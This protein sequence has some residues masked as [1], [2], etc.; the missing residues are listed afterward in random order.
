MAVFGAAAFI[1]DIVWFLFIAIIIQSL[2][3][4]ALAYFIAILLKNT[5]IPLIVNFT[6]S[7]IF[8]LAGGN[9]SLNIFAERLTDASSLGK[10]VWV[11]IAAFILLYGG[12]QMEKHLYKNSI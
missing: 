6:Y 2:F 8:M 5:F 7:L 4:S 9:L 10:Y 3:L 12:L 1:Y 11:S